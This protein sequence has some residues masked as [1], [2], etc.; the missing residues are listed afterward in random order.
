MAFSALQE[1]FINEYLK[2]RNGAEAARRAGYSEKTARTIAAQNLAKLDIQE[3]IKRR[4]AEGAME[5]DEVL[6]RLADTARGTME[7]FVSFNEGPYPEFTLD[8]AKA[9]ER[10]KLHLIKKLKYD[11]DGNPEIEL[12]SALDAQKVLVQLLTG[13]PSGSEED[14]IHHAISYIKEV[15]P[16]ATE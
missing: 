15:R 3:E 11:K 6:S 1:A 14:P 4:T 5:S 16:S 13:G 7:D 9:R 2:C 8:L 12:Y 10:N